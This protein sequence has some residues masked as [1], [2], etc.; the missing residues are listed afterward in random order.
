MAG[1]VQSLPVIALGDRPDLIECA[2][3]WF[4]SIWGVA[5]EDYRTSMR[6]CVQGRTA[7]PQWYIVCDNGRIAAGAGVIDNDFHERRDL[8]P[9]VC[10]VYVQPEYRRLGV[11]RRLLDAVCHDM[12]R[13]GVP[14]LYLLTDHD[15][16]YERLGWQFVGMV[17]DD[18]GELGRMY[19][20][21]MPDGCAE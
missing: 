14:H 8:A 7:I 19:A 18:D 11:A 21:R 2:A 5:T 15:G 4:S 12:A 9:N 6:A 13:Q 16:F 1:R 3:E 10:A 20:H 17:R